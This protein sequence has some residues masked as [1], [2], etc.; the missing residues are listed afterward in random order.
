MARLIEVALGEDHSEESKTGLEGSIALVGSI[1][2]EDT[3]K[4]LGETVSFGATISC[5]L[6][7]LCFMDMVFFSVA[8][9]PRGVIFWTKPASGLM[10]GSIPFK[11]RPDSQVLLRDCSTSEVKV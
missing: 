2:V 10:E 11:Q 1:D 7:L 6:A 9:G 3:N 5:L 4:K 8:D